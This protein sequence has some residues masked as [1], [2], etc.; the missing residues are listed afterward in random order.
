[1]GELRQAVKGLSEACRFF[2]TPVT[3]GN[4]SLYNQSSGTNIKPT[5]TIGMVGMIP[6]LEKVVPSYFSDPSAMVLLLGDVKEHKLYQS[7]Y[8][9]TVLLTDDLACPPIDLKNEL[10]LQK[11]LLEL[12]EKRLLTSAHDCSE[13]GLFQSLVECCT[14]HP[15]TAIGVK[16]KIP[17]D[18]DAV[19]FLFGESVSRVVISFNP[20]NFDEIRTI[21]NS[22][23]VS[24]T[25]LGQLGGSTLEVQGQFQF[26]LSELTNYREKLLKEI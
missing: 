5:P 22:F 16:V 12:S 9:R 7:E 10:S 8:A 19:L 20:K 24:V 26:S 17:T 15:R 13:G 3:G 23:D 1:M 4:V 6:D 25:K 18:L 2:Q 11:A 21:L 14:S